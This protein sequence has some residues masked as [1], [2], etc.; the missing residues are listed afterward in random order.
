MPFSSSLQTKRQL[1]AAIE[2]VKWQPY[3]R[4][5]V[6]AFAP[7]GSDLS[8]PREGQPDSGQ[9]RDADI[10]QFR[11][12]YFAVGTLG[13]LNYVVRGLRELPGRKSIVL[14]SEGFQIF[15]SEDSLVNDRIL[16]ALRRLT[17]LANRASVVIYTMDPRGVQTL[18]LTAAD[19]TG[20]M[21]PQQVEQQLSNRSSALFE[22][23]SG[24]DYLAAQTG[25]IS[26]K[27]S[28]DLAGGMKRIIADQEGY[29]L[30]GYRPDDT[31]FDRVNGRTKFHHISLKI[32]R[33][34]KYNIRMRNGFYGV[35]DEVVTPTAAQ[36]PQQ[37]NPE[38]PDAPHLRS[39]GFI[40]ILLRFFVNEAQ[41][42]SA[43]RS[44]LHV[45]PRD[46][47][48]HTRTRRNA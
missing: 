37:A 24:L 38:R 32:R 35:S 2:K 11:E 33:A 9:T 10:D 7:L 44:M 14:F 4:G 36:T 17:D 26:I 16:F 30:I 28:N 40:F 23:Q 29:Y 19:S 43:M 39:Q 22:S 1:Y 21:T 18:G 46:M 42:G 47:R 12:D 15:N 48:F 45:D 5:N 31:T 6:S 3:G 34:G 20:M 41:T 8:V 25:G 13:A 27:N